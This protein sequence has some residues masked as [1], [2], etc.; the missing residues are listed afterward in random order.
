MEATVS[1][2]HVL[3][4]RGEAAPGDGLGGT[5]FELDDGLGYGDRPD[6]PRRD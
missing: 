3:A 2:M 6:D 5:G 1:E 4:V